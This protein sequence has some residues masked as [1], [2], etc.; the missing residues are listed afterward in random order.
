MIRSGCLADLQL[1]R[2]VLNHSM[3]FLAIDATGLIDS[4]GLLQNFILLFKIE[5]YNYLA[6]A[7]D[8]YRYR[9]LYG[10]D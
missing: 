5:N 9:M 1:F 8:G 6:I 3:Q 4:V 10:I 2:R 7:T